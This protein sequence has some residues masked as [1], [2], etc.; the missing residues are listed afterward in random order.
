MVETICH[1]LPFPSQRIAC[2]ISRTHKRFYPGYPLGWSRRT[3]EHKKIT[4]QFC[5]W[6]ERITGSGSRYSSLFDTERPQSPE[7]SPAIQRMVLLIRH[8]Q[9]PPRPM[10]GK[11]PCETAS[12]FNLL[13][14]HFPLHVVDS[15]D[16]SYCMTDGLPHSLVGAVIA[17]AGSGA[18]PLNLARYLASSFAAASTCSRLSLIRRCPSHWQQ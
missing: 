2:D 15:R 9:A 17:Y 1:L 12:I 18:K 14:K 10:E 4:R 8:C 3:T 11:V 16:R 7:D 5:N 13:P 6:R